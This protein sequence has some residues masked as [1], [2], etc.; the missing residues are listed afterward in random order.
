M[1]RRLRAASIAKPSAPHKWF[2]DFSVQPL[3]SLCLCRYR[4][5]RYIN[6]RDTENTEGCTEKSVT[7][8]RVPA[9]RVQRIAGTDVEIVT[10][11]RGCGPY[12]IIQI[13]R[14]N[15]FPLRVSFEHR[16]F[17]APAREKDLAVRCDGRC[18]GFLE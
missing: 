13:V 10:G 8:F 5:T 9:E 18:V 6:H 16:H 17:A 15:Y 12:L 1:P 4:N 14:R 11:D 7:L 2:R 3:C